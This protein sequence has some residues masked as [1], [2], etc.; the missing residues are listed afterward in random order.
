L[1]VGKSD[2]SRGES[3]GDL[4]A[5]A[6]AEQHRRV[7]RSEETIGQRLRRLR[8]EGGLSQRQ[9]A[10][11]ALTTAYIS[12]I[13]SGQR[14]PSVKAIRQIA[15]RLG[16]S[17][18]YLETGS[19]V[20]AAER[21][22]S[23][24][25]EAELE[26]RLAAGTAA[27]ESTF[28]RVLAEAAEAA[29]FEAETRARAGLGLAAAYAGRPREAIEALE[30]VIKAP[31]VSPLTRPDLYATLARSYATVRESARAIELLQRCLEELR[32]RE[33]ENASGY[34]RF[35]TYLSYAL[36]DEGDHERARAA[37]EDAITRAG[38]ARDPYTRVR[39]YW[40]QARLASADGDYLHAQASLRR[41]VGL[42]EA[43]DDSIHLAQAHRLWAEVLLDDE[44]PD[45][46]REHLE[47]ASA[48]FGPALEAKDNALLQLE[49][50]RVQLADGDAE[51]AIENAE[52]ALAISDDEASLHGRA[53][54]LLALGHATLS[55][56]TAAAHFARAAELIRPRS[57]YR[58]RFLADW[59]DFLQREG[60]V[61][62]AANVL[63]EV[64]LRDL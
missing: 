17:P 2:G 18:E 47:Q 34:V 37:I 53:E 11:P 35:A 30:Q 28:R 20:S 38:E 27:A 52:R 10:G 23:L 14:V 51:Q 6:G 5:G 13:E 55:D 22:R 12:R 26:L 56:S 44:Q 3:H 59:A 1:T 24:L 7:G 9:A 25:D 46:A 42:L 4:T 54:W 40:S 33:P 43:I 49:Y 29:D 63:K 50:A 41:A 21:R 61:D 39:L 62:E 32:E 45:A 36:T 31:G 60:R 15:Q 16:V 19:A 48:L 64:V 8:T 58:K 57:R